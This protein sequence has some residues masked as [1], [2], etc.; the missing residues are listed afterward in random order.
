MSE[1]VLCG[2][3]IGGT[4]LSVGLVSREGRLIDSAMFYD[5]VNRDPD[6]IMS[7]IEG[8]VR[9]LLEQNSIGEAALRGIGVGT[10]GHLRYRDG[11][12][13]TMSNL[14]GFRGYPIRDRLQERFHARINVD[15]DANAQAYGEYRYGAGKGYSELVFVT[16]STQIGAGIILGGRLYRGVTGTAGEFGHTIVAPDTDQVCPCGNRGCL[17]SV[18]SGVALP[19]AA[20]K[21]VEG[22]LKSPLFGGAGF[23][24]STVTG[25]LIKRGLDAEDPVSLAVVREFAHYIGIA[26]YNIFQVFNPQAIILGGGLLSWGDVFFEGIRTTFNTLIREMLYDDLAIVRAGVGAHSGVIGA[27]S[28]ALEET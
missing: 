4:K 5:H 17:I 18:A 22:G 11:T 6:A 28:L 1:E 23:D 9:T 12:L 26:V 13:I 24:F 19:A 10:A 7:Q 8:A 14:R 25:E 20:R 2:V 27:A 15:N 21:K 3:D 16:L